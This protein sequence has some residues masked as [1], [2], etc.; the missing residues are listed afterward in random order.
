M[1]SLMIMFR[2]MDFD[3]SVGAGVI[4]GDGDDVAV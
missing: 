3:R 2:M 4:D 1:M